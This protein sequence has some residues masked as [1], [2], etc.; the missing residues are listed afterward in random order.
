MN[1]DQERLVRAHTARLAAEAEERDAIM[2]ALRERSVPQAEIARITGVSTETVRQ[3]RQ[4]AGIPPDK[5]KIRFGR[6]MT[7]Q[8]PPDAGRPAGE[9]ETA[10]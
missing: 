2:T 5:R 8:V 9:A 7:T 3:L 10:G 1:A 6:S 4:A